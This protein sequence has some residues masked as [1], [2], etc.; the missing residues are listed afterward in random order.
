MFIFDAYGE[1]HNAFKNISSKVP[2][3]SFKAYTT[4]TGITDAEVLTIGCKI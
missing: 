2:E 1:Y 3:I 4:D